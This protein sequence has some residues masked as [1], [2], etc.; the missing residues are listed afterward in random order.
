MSAQVAESLIF[1]R[2]TK[3]P[4]MERFAPRWQLVSQKRT[5]CETLITSRFCPFMTRNYSSSETW[6]LCRMC[7]MMLAGA[8]SHIDPTRKY[9]NSSSRIAAVWIVIIRFERGGD[10][11]GERC[12]HADDSNINCLNRRYAKETSFEFRA[13]FVQPV[14]RLSSSRSFSLSSTFNGFEANY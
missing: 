10:R 11:L 2:D 6:R 1:F 4:L 9:S 8:I 7:E 12:K 13:H 3:D 14:S 5:T